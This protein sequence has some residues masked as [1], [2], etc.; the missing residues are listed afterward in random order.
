MSVRIYLSSH[1]R[2]YTGGRAEVEAE[3]GTLAEVMADLERHYPG[4]RFR[5]ID[6]QDRIRP[7]MNFFV[8]EVLARDLRHPIRPGDEVHILGSLSGG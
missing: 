7:H 8:G 1:V 5:V 2:S 3:G 6:E 4:I